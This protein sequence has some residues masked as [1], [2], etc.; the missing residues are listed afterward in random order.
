MKNK[1][2]VRSLLIENAIRII[3]VGGFESATT[4]E[5]AHS[6]GILPDLKM[7]ETY[8]YRLFES[9]EGVYAA[10]FAFLDRELCLAFES[11]IA[12]IE[13]FKADLKKSF[14]TL[15]MKAWKFILH[16]QDNCRCYVRYYYSVYFKGA[17]LEYHKR[18]F[19]GMIFRLSSFFNEEADVEAILHSV[20]TT[21][22]NF[23][24]RVFNGELED[25]EVNR[26][27][28]FN[29]LYCMMSTYFKASRQATGISL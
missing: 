20:F 15:F 21:L 22:L 5:L 8:I 19:K 12:D 26:Y 18:L 17:S 14:Y 11:G 2:T 3:A 13:F 6:G 25:S 23:A 28:I 27:H 10:A 24:I 4:K 7:N 16:N 29:V 1:E 9:K